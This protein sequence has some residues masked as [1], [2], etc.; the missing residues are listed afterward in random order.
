M[1]K[2]IYAKMIRYE[3]NGRFRA[4]RYYKHDDH[5]SI[6]DK[7]MEWTGNDHEISSDAASWCE[8]AYVGETYEFREGVIEIIEID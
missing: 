2:G 4:T 5:Y 3:M 8:L 7:M 6:Y 1:P